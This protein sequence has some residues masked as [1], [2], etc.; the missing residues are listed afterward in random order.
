MDVHQTV[1]ISIAQEAI[2]SNEQLR[3]AEKRVT[4]TPLLTAKQL[5]VEVANR[6]YV[7]DETRCLEAEHVIRVGKV[8]VG[9]R[10]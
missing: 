5:W 3:L 2:R 1:A 4:S 9:L 7:P 6:Q 10:A 8:D